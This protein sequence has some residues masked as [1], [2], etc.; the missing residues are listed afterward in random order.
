MSASESAD[1]LTPDQALRLAAF[2]RACKAA[3]RVV[4][5][6]P[7]THPALQASLERVRDTAEQLRAAGNLTLTILPD[8]ILLDSRAPQKPD[9]SL[10]EL[11]ALLHA[12][13][14]GELSLLGELT[15]VGWH[16]F[17]TL[18][19]RD[20]QDIRAE[21]GIQRAWMTAGGGPIELRQIDYTEVLRERTGGLS[22]EWDRLIANYLEGELSDLDDAAMNAL[23]DIAGDPNRFKEFTERLVARA[24][25][26]G[27]RG[28]KDV[29]LRVLQA[30]VDFVARVNP[31]QLDS[32]LHQIA[33]VVPQLTP[34]LVLT[35]ITTGAPMEEGAER[36]IDLPF[37][38]RSRINDDTVAQFVAQSVSRDRGATERL[39]QV[40]QTL[41]P[42]PGRRAELL[43]MAHDELDAMPIGRQADFPDL[44]K[45]AED[46]LTSYSDSAF[47]TE[48]YARELSTARTHAIEV[49]RVSDDPPERIGRW[50]AS[51]SAQEVRKLDQQLLLDLLTIEMREDAWRKVLDTAAAH[52][53]NLV[54][55]GNIPFAQEM[56]EAIIAATAAGQPFVAAA[57]EALERLRQGPLMKHVVLAIRQAQES[58]LAGIATFCRTLGPEVMGALAEA[59]A[60]EPGSATVRRLRDVLFSFG[61]AGR[62]HADELRTSANPAVRRTAIELLRAFGGA[63][64]L[65]DLA[66]LLDDSEPAVQR[67]AL[68]AIVQIGTDEAYGTLEQALRTGTAR[69]HDV[70]MTVLAS[71]RDERSVPLFVYILEHT[72]FRGRLESVYLSAIDAL[73][74]VGGDAESVA[75][76]RTVLC[77]G[78]WWA[79]RRT[80]RMR[81]AAAMA[82]RASGSDLARETLEEVANDG[83]RGARRAARAALAAAAPATARKAT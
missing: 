8:G 38:V 78:D 9:A 16:T 36:G 50:L 34:E 32:I 42:E 70:I 51:V 14:I 24:T 80:R 57:Q 6:Y 4:A 64:A 74:K 67:E 28:K 13:L 1:P 11:A 39:A 76:L 27:R 7:A 10:G 61:A 53:E 17:L 68:R 26:G 65:P 48:E 77:R 23:F 15:P 25:E 73:G 12:H 20:P 47:V 33:G 63:D 35:L 43:G 52:T 66:G 3:T 49:E 46:L 19:S 29:V 60:N 82:L 2:A 75:A 71:S 30:L 72:D 54:L 37:E 5:L 56:L 62:V 69:T 21:G 83:P 55:L 22:A 40:F 81:A 59:L 44:W 45:K 18:L 58:E 79:L 41:V 31:G